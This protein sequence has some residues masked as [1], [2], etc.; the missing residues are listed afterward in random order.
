MKRTFAVLCC[1]GLL[2]ACTQKEKTNKVTDSKMDKFITELMGKM[3]LEE[4]IGQLNLPAAGDITTGQAKSSDIDSKIKAG[5]VGGLFNIKGVEKIREVQ[6]VAV[7]ES[8]MK[9]PLLFAM[10]VIHGY[11]TVFPIPLGLSCSWDIP[12]IEE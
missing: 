12:G 1:I 9:I 4:K 2:C 3:T 6:R 5:Q 7:E 11:E 8:R 10:D